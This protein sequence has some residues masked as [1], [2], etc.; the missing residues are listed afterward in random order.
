M[1]IRSYLPNIIGHS[2]GYVYGASYQMMQKYLSS[3]YQIF[4]IKDNIY[5]GD[6]ASACQLE[7]LKEDG[8]THILSIVN[9]AYPE[10]PS[11]F[12]Y[13]IIHI[14]DD[15][16]LSIDAHFDECIKFIEKSQLNNGKILI[17]CMYG[18]SRSPVIIAA[19][20]IKK[21]KMSTQNAINMI[22]N[23]KQNVNPNEGF[24]NQLRKYEKMYKL[25]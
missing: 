18:I 11:D 19:Y 5:L 12:T 25:I 17:H 24:L 20:L 7:K 9:G 16:W 22:K 3:P 13:N 14:N 10:Y 21:Y 6:M 1:I 2:M 15:T 23:K 4:H 8:I